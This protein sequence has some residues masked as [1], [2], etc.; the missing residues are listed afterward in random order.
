MPVSVVPKTPR[1]QRNDLVVTHPI[2]LSMTLNFSVSRY[3]VLQNPHE[4]CK[5]ARVAF[6]DAIA[7]P[8]NEVEESSAGAGALSWG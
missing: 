1:S 7:D 8:D 2:C 6:E 4:A 5:M 3:G